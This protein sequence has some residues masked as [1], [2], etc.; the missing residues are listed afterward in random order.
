MP[1]L[2]ATAEPAAT[3]P[4][5]V[6]DLN[7]ADVVPVPT[8]ATVTHLDPDGRTRPV[9]LADP[10]TLTSG[11]ATLFDFESPFGQPVTY[12]ACAGSTT[13]TSAAVTLSPEHAW[14]RHPNVPSLSVELRTV[15]A[16]SFEERPRRS[17]RALHYVL[18]RDTPIAVTSGS[19]RSPET[20]LVVRTTTHTEKRRLL[21][22]L[23]AEDVLLLTVPAGFGWDIDHEYLS[24]GD[25]TESRLPGSWGELPER[26]VSLPYVVVDRP[27]GGVQALFVWADV[28]AQHATWA[29]VVQRFTDWGDLVANQRNDAAPA[30]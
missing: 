20:T 16:A 7:M 6:L 5:V 28:V 19:R 15:N 9:R 13:V 1:T 3:P 2:T 10:A 25:V 17:T 21:E 11:Q 30:A 23:R 26:L 12:T 18:G 22:A 14:L 8:S 24:V 27:A 29:D 4:R